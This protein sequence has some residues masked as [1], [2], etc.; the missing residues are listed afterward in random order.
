MKPS[1][2]KG[3]CYKYGFIYVGWLI[4][5]TEHERPL[6]FNNTPYETILP[7]TKLDYLTFG[8]TKKSVM[9]RLEKHIKKEKTND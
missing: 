6:Y 8:F 4:K 5:Y 3:Y 7:E 1:K 2:F 9:K